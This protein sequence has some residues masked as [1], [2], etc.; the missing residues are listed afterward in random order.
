M[1]EARRGPRFTV[2]SALGT[3]RRSS[4]SFHPRIGERFVFRMSN[5]KR[6]AHFRAAAVC[7]KATLVHTRITLHR[8]GPE[9]MDKLW[10]FVV[11]STGFV[12][13]SEHLPLLRLN[14]LLLRL[15]PSVRP[16]LFTHVSIS[17]FFHGLGRVKAH[18]PDTLLYLPPHPKHTYYYYSR[19]CA[20]MFFL[21]IYVY[22]LF[23]YYFRAYIYMYIY[24]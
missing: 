16:P 1:K 2:V 20:H 6:D 5:I 22:I 10:H 9:Q 8:H 4:T 15:P 21:Y 11:G 17:L 18:L 19:P 13:F 3:S 14:L 7:H 24:I 12:L 23:T